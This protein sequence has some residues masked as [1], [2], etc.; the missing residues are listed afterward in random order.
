MQLFFDIVMKNVVTELMKFVSGILII[1]VFMSGSCSRKNSRDYAPL[2][3][4]SYL[5][6]GYEESPEINQ[7][8]T[9]EKWTPSYLA[10]D[11]WDHTK[12]EAKIIPGA[13]AEGI[14]QYNEDTRLIE[15]LKRRY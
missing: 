13:V 1:T 2:P 10:R 11:F 7:Y 5:H 3:D 9:F 6:N 15:R 12:E 4:G 8:G 14:D